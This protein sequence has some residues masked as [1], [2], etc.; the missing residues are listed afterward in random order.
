[1]TLAAKPSR[2]TQYST[3]YA[4]NVMSKP[5]QVG[6]LSTMAHPPMDWIASVK[7]LLRKLEELIEFIGGCLCLLLKWVAL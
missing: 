1:M 7:I 5:K 2:V 4:K 6:E 3:R